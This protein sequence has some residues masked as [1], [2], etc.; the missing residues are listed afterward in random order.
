MEIWEQDALRS[1]NYGMRNQVD[2]ML[3]LLAEQQS[4]VAEVRQQIEAARHSAKSADGSVEV[5]V[6]SSGV[7]VEVQIADAAL[8]GTAEQLG[9]SVAE[10]GRAAARQAQEQT[11]QLLAP[12]AE[13]MPDL[14]DLVPGA[15]SLR[16]SEGEAAHD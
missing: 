13:E 16:E 5:T 2:R 12:F 3:D 4:R 15:P 14:P 11:R 10:A 8:R 9:R 1:A 6:D 7:L